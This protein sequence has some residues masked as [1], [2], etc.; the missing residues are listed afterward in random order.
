MTVPLAIDNRAEPCSALASPDHVLYLAD[1]AG[2]TVFDR[3]F[4]EAL[5]TPV[6]YAVKGGAVLNGATRQDAL[7]AGLGTCATIS[8][9]GSRAPGTILELCS[10]AFRDTFESAPLVIAKG[11]ANYETLS[12][13]GS[14]VFCLLQ[15]KC[16]VIADD[17]QAPV[18]SAVVRQSIGGPSHD[19]SAHGPLVLRTDRRTVLR[20]NSVPPCRGPCLTEHTR[21]PPRSSSAAP[22]PVDN[23]Q[24]QS[25]SSSGGTERWRRRRPL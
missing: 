23:S 3:V 6:L 1:T 2:E 25:H 9:N 8:E 19:R 4:I 22:R 11:Q 10:A 14:R 17:M 5:E 15:V 20:L 16:P 13:A 18:G 12:V 7:A 24:K 21:N